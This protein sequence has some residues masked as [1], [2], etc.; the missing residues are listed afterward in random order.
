MEGTLAVYENGRVDLL[1]DVF[2]WAYERSCKQFKA[3][4]HALPEPDPFRMK[5][6]AQLAEVVS[7]VVRSGSPIDTQSIR[8]LAARIVPG[9]DLPRFLKMS[10]EELRGLHEG[11]IA[12]FRLGLAEFRAWSGQK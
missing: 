4:A 9:E 10:L 2:I 8:P 1:R 12:R 5:Y 6:R 3:M 7:A 11:N